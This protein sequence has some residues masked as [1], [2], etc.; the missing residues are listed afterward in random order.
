M[1]E[2]G[3]SENE[4]PA[5][6]HAQYV[7]P[8]KAYCDFLAS[9]ARDTRTDVSVRIFEDKFLTDELQ[10][11]R[12][13]VKFKGSFANDTRSFDSDVPIYRL[14]EAY[15]LKAE[16]ENALGNTEVA[17]KNLNVV[18]KRAYG[19]DN[20]YTLTSDAIDNAI[21]DEI[22]KEFVAE[23]K[24][25]WAYLRFNKEFELIE[26]LKGREA[27]KNVTLWPVAP[28][29]LNTNPNISQTEGYK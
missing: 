23:S 22:L 2:A 5:G 9:D 8:T 13:I 15:L 12:M 19:V 24:S 3:Y 26:T 4:V 7:V 10:L 14:A 16:V 29:C 17:L 20:Y 25:W 11:K 21:I 28:A 27:E 6:S 1:R 18:A